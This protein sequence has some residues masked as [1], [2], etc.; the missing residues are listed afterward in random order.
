[1]NR[2]VIIR[3]TR[4]GI[5]ATIAAVVVAGMWLY[6]FTYFWLDDFNNVYWI[7]R[8]GFWRLIGDILNPSSLFFRPLGMLVYW[9]V[10]RVAALHSLPYHL[11]SWALHSINTALVFFLL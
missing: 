9:I 3:L 10:F 6:T 2:T 4:Y 7:R 8:E 1:M 5:P 11:L